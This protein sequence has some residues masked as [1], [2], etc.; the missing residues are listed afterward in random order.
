MTR[1]RPARTYHDDSTW[2]HLELGPRDD[3][4]YFE[5]LIRAIFQAGLSWPVIESHWPAFSEVFHDFDPVQ[6]AAMTEEDISR[7]AQDPRII[8]AHH[9]RPALTSPDR[10]DEPVE[11]IAFAAPVHQ[12]GRTALPPGMCGHRP[13]ATP[14]P[15]RPA[16]R[17]CSSGLLRPA[18]AMPSL[19]RSVTCHEGTGKPSEGRYREAVE[20]LGR[21]RLRPELARAHLLYGEWL[22]RENRRQAG[23][24]S[25]ARL[26]PAGSTTGAVVAGR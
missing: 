4:R 22:R 12:S 13:G 26:G 8:A 15:G 24:T 21:T 25:G 17:E 23:L 2:P 11:R 19:G 7:A 10:D 16:G 1:Y 14:H 18:G 6:V 3:R 9:Q 5:Q 20:R